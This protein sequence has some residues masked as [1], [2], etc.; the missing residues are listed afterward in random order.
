[1]LAAH[2]AL[3][4]GSTKGVGRSIVEALAAAGADVLVHGRQR[5]PEAE[6]VLSNC[7]R[8]GVRAEFV[9]GDLAGPTTTA[10]DAL[11]QAATGIYPRLDLLVNNAG[12]YIDRPFLEMDFATYEHT[13]RLNVA[14]PYFLT[15]RFARRWVD[16]GIRAGSC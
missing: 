13:M 7:R 1:M 4:T 14:A 3:V 16:E 12:T 6:Q 10:V 11:F 2:S 9:E 5:N 8:H 15:Q